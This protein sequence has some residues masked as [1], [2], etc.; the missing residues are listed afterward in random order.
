MPEITARVARIS[1]ISREVQ[2]R[3]TDS[4]DWERAVQNLPIVEGDEIATSGNALLEIQLN[5]DSYLRLAQNS[6]VK[7]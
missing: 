6:Y 7:F 4:R 1:Y 3:R 2:I 5:K